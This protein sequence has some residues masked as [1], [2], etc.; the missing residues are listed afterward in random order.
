MTTHLCLRACVY[1]AKEHR[2]HK[3]HTHTHEHLYTQTCTH[4]LTTHL[5]LCACVYT[6]KE[7]RAPA[8]RAS[9][10][11]LPAS[12]GKNA[13]QKWCV[14]VCNYLWRRQ[15]IGDSWVSLPLLVYI[16]RM[17]IW[18][19][20]GGGICSSCSWMLFMHN[21]RMFFIQQKD[22]VLRALRC[23]SCTTKGCSSFNKRMLFYMLLDVVHA[24]Q[25]KRE[26]GGGLVLG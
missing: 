20:R 4:M 2:A 10:Q 16:L 25:K 6:A 7:H 14:Y 21:K 12:E 23:C 8:D 26:G 24:Q 17:S 5:C 11:R 9:Q 22:V 3:P 15:V 19:G 13:T 18:G 1:T